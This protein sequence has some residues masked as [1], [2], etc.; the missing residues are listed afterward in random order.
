MCTTCS[1]PP[2][3]AARWRSLVHEGTHDRVDGDWES[4]SLRTSPRALPRSSAAM[5][6]L[7]P[8]GSLG[9]ACHASR[10]PSHPE[11]RAE[12]PAVSQPRKSPPAGRTTPTGGTPSS[13]SGPEVP[14]FLWRGYADP[15][16]ADPSGAPLPLPERSV[17][18]DLNFPAARQI[19]DLAIAAAGAG[20]SAQATVGTADTRN[21]RDYVVVIPILDSAGGGIAKAIWTGTRSKLRRPTD[22]RALLA[23]IDAQVT[24]SGGQRPGGRV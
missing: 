6:Y 24:N 15:G 11:S 18:R 14:L 17:D 12:P 3:S 7:P 9:A 19:R 8:R 13:R 4:R 10:N 20:S 22:P 5:I 23:K 16:V 21:Q 1:L 2:C